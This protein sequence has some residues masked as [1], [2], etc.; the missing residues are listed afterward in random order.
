MSETPRKKAR[1]EQSFKSTYS[2]IFGSYLGPSSKGSTYVHCSICNTDFSCAHAGR[3]DCKR[4]IESKS[5]KQWES[6]RKENKSIHDFGGRRDDSVQ[7][8]T[9]K[10]E[11]K[12]CELIAHM[13]LP[14]IFFRSLNS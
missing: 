1:Y 7:L 4:H 14:L 11:V 5:H 3:N 2:Q 9:T 12:M 10:A 8:G 13:N 6:L